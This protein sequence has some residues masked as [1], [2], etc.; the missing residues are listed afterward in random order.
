MTI[1]RSTTISFYYSFNEFV[2]FFQ[3]SNRDVPRRESRSEIIEPGGVRQ[4]NGFGGGLFH[5]RTAST[6]GAGKQT[7]YGGR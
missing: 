3:I 5:H 7:Q 4:A 6:T 2:V 1:W